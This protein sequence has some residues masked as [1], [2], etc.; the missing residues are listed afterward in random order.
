M[1]DFIQTIVDIDVGESDAPLLAERARK[2][3]HDSKVIDA[4]SVRELLA[5][6][7]G[8]APGDDALRVVAPE[9]RT[10]NRESWNRN[11]GAA[12]VVGRQVFDTGENGV[13]LQCKMCSAQIIGEDAYIEA[14]ESWYNGDESTPFTCPHCHYS[15]PLRLWDGPYI[16]GFGSLG[17]AF[18][19]WPPLSSKFVLDVATMLGHKVRLVRQHL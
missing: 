6:D 5:T 12:L 4:T 9:F 17:I 13:E 14:I 2:W 19:N 11:A 3:L 7:N 15:Q 10:P 8:F 1:S 18:E 16:F